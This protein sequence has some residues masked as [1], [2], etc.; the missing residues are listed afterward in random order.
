MCKLCQCQQPGLTILMTVRM[1]QTVECCTRKAFWAEM[2]QFDKEH[3]FPSNW[4]RTERKPIRCPFDSRFM[5]AASTSP[6]QSTAEHLLSVTSSLAGP[7]IRALPLT[8][9][10]IF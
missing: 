5:L 6:T 7:D 2:D 9:S 3:P 4:S 8:A 1:Q 10:H